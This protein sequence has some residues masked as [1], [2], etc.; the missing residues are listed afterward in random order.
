MDEPEAKRALASCE[1]GGLLPFV[2]VTCA[3]CKEK[4]LCLRCALFVE[5]TLC[6]ACREESETQQ[7]AVAAKEELKRVE[8]L[9]LRKL[10]G[11]ESCGLR[12]PAQCRSCRS[13]FCGACFEDPTEHDCVRCQEHRCSARFVHRCP[14]QFCRSTRF[15]DPCFQRRHN[16]YQCSGCR[17]TVNRSGA[18]RFMCPIPGCERV[19]GCHYCS[20]FE[21]RGGIVCFEHSSRCARCDSRY[22]L[23]RNCVV[24]L[25]RICKKEMPCCPPCYFRVRAL[26]ECIVLRKGPRMP[27]ELIEMI[28]VRAIEH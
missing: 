1:C 26:I 17:M 18:A 24:L 25:G 15:C 3:A 16:S 19:Y 12:D 2:T 7:A 27:R 11:N 5:V 8:E 28:I 23:R 21:G 4:P 13:F 10:C 22:P 9:A 14:C 6:I 20:L